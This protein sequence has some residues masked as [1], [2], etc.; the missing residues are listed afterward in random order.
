MDFYGFSRSK[1]SFVDDD[2]L[3][4]GAPQRLEALKLEIDLLNLGRLFPVVEEKELNGGHQ[5]GKLVVCA[6][7]AVEIRNLDV[8]L[9]FYEN[10]AVN[11]Q[12]LVAEILILGTEGAE[13]GQSRQSGVE[14]GV[15]DDFEIDGFAA[16]FEE[17]LHGH[18][19]RLLTQD[20][21]NG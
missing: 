15:V 14:K 16:V 4:A 7:S 6:E 17:Y 8:F 18:E 10:P 12:R 11:A 9:A 1:L 13:Q 5:V 20:A 3:N 19:N 21:V 2:F